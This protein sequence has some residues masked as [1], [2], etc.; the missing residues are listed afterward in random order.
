[1]KIDARFRVELTEVLRKG[2]VN[3]FSIPASDFFDANEFDETE[4]G[5]D[6]PWRQISLA[7]YLPPKDKEFFGLTVTITDRNTSQVRSIHMQNLGA[8]SITFSWDDRHAR[9][10]EFE[11]ILDSSTGDDESVRVARMAVDEKKV[12]L[13]CHVQIIGGEVTSLLSDDQ[14]P[15]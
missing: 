9:P 13:T 2:G 10:G 15:S 6:L 12:Q 5:C 14:N 4:W 1:M 8:T 7:D 11:V 3:K